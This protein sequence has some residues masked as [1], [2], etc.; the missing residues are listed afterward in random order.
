MWCNSTFG[1]QQSATGKPTGFQK[2]GAH[3]KDKT[4]PA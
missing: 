3:T 2:Y 1:T 4:V